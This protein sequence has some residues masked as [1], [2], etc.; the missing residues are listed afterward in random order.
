MENDGKS[1]Q[2]L[3]KMLL[4]KY[5]LTTRNNFHDS[6]SENFNC[7]LHTVLISRN[8]ALKTPYLSG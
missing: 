1:L 8:Q 3:L 4:N 5:N 2:N 6:R 7:F